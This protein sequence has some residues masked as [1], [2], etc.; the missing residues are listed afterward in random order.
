M[1]Q[2]IMMVRFQWE[3]DVQHVSSLSPQQRFIRQMQV[4]LEQYYV[5][6][7]MLYPYLMITN[8]KMKWKERGFNQPEVI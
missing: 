7:D 8:P 5:E 4:I 6:K 3:Q 1:L 2:A